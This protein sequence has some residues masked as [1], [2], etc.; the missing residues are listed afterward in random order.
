MASR[1]IE[2]SP[3]AQPL[4]VVRPWH[5]LRLPVHQTGHAFLQL[6]REQIHIPRSASLSP[7]HLQLHHRLLFLLQAQ[8]A[9]V[10]LGAEEHGRGHVVAARSHCSVSVCPAVTHPSKSLPF[11]A[12]STTPAPSA[13]CS[14]RLVCVFG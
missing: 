12:A 6:Q 1:R 13:P 3:A 2:R 14:P 7:C 5:V 10:V 9:Y 8:D 4:A 11:S